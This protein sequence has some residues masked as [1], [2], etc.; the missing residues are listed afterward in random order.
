MKNSN[1]RSILFKIII[2]TWLFNNILFFFDS[3]LIIYNWIICS[4][5]HSK[6]INFY[7]HLLRFF[8]FIIGWL[9]IVFYCILHRKA[10]IKFYNLILCTVISISIFTLG[11]SINYYRDYKSILRKDYTVDTISKDQITS[12]LPVSSNY[13][14]IISYNNG[15][16]FVLSSADYNKIMTRFKINELD[17]ANKVKYDANN[18]SVDDSNENTIKICYLKYT[19]NIVEVS[20]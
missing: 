7:C 11:L 10:K 18:S 16:R 13:L 17:A 8:I 3:E 9:L 14:N 2:L 15:D 20:D 12:I 5:S 1:A 4:F 19:G 6:Y